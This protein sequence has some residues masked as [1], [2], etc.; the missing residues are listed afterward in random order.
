[1][2]QVKKETANIC[3]YKVGNNDDIDNFVRLWKTRVCLAGA[4]VHV[5]LKLATQEVGSSD[6]VQ[7]CNVLSLILWNQWNHS[8]KTQLFGTILTWTVIV[9]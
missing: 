4:A 9:Y 5:A 1:M 2:L 3:Q 7:G 6:N 8:E